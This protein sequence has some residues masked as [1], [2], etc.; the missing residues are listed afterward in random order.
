MPIPSVPYDII[1]SIVQYVPIQKVKMLVSMLSP[2]LSEDDRAEVYHR[3]S[4][5]LRYFKQLIKNPEEL[6]R[7]M[8]M[9]NVI[10]SGS[11]A[12]EYFSPGLIDEDSDWDFYIRNDRRAA[13]GFMYCLNRAGVEWVDKSLNIVFKDDPNNEDDHSSADSVDAYI[14]GLISYATGY[15]YHNGKRNKIQLIRSAERY[16]CAEYNLGN[17]HSSI[18]Q[19]YISGSSAVCMYSHLTSNYKSLYWYYSNPA[20]GPGIGT[21]RYWTT[22]TT[23]RPKYELRG[24]QYIG[25]DLYNNTASRLIESNGPFN[26]SRIRSINDKISYI[27]PYH[28]YVQDKESTK[29]ILNSYHS[30]IE[31]TFWTEMPYHIKWDEY[32]VNSTIV[33]S[34]HMMDVTETL[35]KR[36]NYGNKA[37][38][39]IVMT[40]LSAYNYRG[41]TCEDPD[42]ML[43]Y[44]G[45]DIKFITDCPVSTKDFIK[46]ALEKRFETLA[47]SEELSE[48]SLQ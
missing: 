1:L 48:D 18:V 4:D 33:I 35:E 12:A 5:P 42:D 31:S 45:M 16:M 37:I 43:G 34:E 8:S 19:C 7:C 25:Y 6:L 23:T 36:W 2:E 38:N 26:E 29:R 28:N 40:I 10:L 20:C 41:Y 13:A 24:V 14:D 15:L 11:R 47:I 27:I 46:S 3:R 22:R 32:A 9:Y 44:Y 30:E 21:N 39:D 17:F